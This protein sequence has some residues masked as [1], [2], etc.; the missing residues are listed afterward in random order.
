MAL[1]TRKV[2][3]TF[4]D[5]RSG[6]VIDE[7]RMKATDL[8]ES[9]APET[10]LNFRDQDW[11]IVSATP[12]TRAEYTKSRTLRLTLS[13]I[14]MI[15]P[16]TLLYSLPTI[17]D[18][19]PDADAEVV[20]DDGYLFVEDLWRQVEFVSRALETDVDA[21]L[22][23][24]AAIHANEAEGIGFRNLHVRS[25]IGS[26]ITGAIP[27][28]DV[29]TACRGCRRTDLGYHPSGQRV[30][31]GFAFVAD[32]ASVLFGV[33]DHDDVS[34]LCFERIGG[35]RAANDIVA[36]LDRLADD[37]GLL[38]VDWCRCVKAAPGTPEFAEI[39]AAT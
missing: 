31:G 35:G 27:L 18:A 4:I 19:L 26:P 21:E 36:A 38:L 25:A 22:S 6:A 1:F 33:A 34:V 20:D 10:T 28:D 5:S 37:H 2:H 23:A 24:I 11:S 7:T 32:D 14:E 29:A 8:P 16:S 3:V 13:P 15:D 17:C 12:V 30:A 39:I 9:F